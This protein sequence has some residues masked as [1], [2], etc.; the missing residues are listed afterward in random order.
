MTVQLLTIQVRRI[1][2]DFWGLSL[3]SN[4][5]L[6]LPVDVA[7][8]GFR[9]VRRKGQSMSYAVGV[10]GEHATSNWCLYII[11]LSRLVTA[12]VRSLVRGPG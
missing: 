9:E 10:C 1:S 4:N 5:G 11:T 7:H 8:Y 3:E 6:A 12:R 2:G